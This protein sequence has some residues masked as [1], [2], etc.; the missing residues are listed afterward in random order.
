MKTIK[1]TS[2][3]LLAFAALFF[4]ACKDEE[5][6]V[7]DDPKVV[8]D[9]SSPADAS[10]FG[11]GDT[12]HIDGMISHTIDMHG[13]EISIINTSHND[14]VVFNKHEHM[15]GKMFHIHEMWVNDVAD[16]S[17]MTLKIDAITDHAGTTETKEIKFHCHPM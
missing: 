9:F 14:T 6:I 5:P 12:I 17:N 10:M 1:N 16:H 13:Y 7:E 3:L 8:F 11:K 15:D 4:T 2:L